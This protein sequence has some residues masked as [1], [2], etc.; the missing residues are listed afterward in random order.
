MGL[1][2]CRSRILKWTELLSFT[3][4]CILLLLLILQPFLHFTYVTTHSPALPSLY[5]RHFT[6]VTTRSPTLTLLFL[7]HSSFSNPSFTSPTSQVLRLRH[8]ASRQYFRPTYWSKTATGY[9]LLLWTQQ[10]VLVTLKDDPSQVCDE[11]RNIQEVRHKIKVSNHSATRLVRNL[12]ETKPTQSRSLFTIRCY[13]DHSELPNRNLKNP[14]EG[15]L[16]CYN[17]LA[18]HPAT[19][20]NYRNC[21]APH[22]ISQHRKVTVRYLLWLEELQWLWFHA[23]E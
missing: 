18:S 10:T 8:L 16:L 22:F 14:L 4:D 17:M 2:S 5:L 7:R 6:Y 12:A 23:T 21:Q 15:W 13:G 11:K 3:F 20:H 1:K 9:L 19:T